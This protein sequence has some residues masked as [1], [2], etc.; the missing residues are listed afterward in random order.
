MGYTF[1]EVPRLDFIR[2]TEKKLMSRQDVIPLRMAK[3]VETLG[4]DIFNSY[5]T[6]AGLDNAL[7]RTAARL[8]TFYHAINEV[9]PL[10]E[11]IDEVFVPFF[12]ELQEFV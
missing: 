3:M 9:E 4:H 5:N 7:D 12:G 10:L 6:I 2:E 11:Q 8:C 1:C